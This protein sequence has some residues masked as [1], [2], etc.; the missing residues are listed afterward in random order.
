MIDVFPPPWRAYAIRPYTFSRNVLGNGNCLGLFAAMKGVCD[1]PLH[2][3]AE[4]FGEMGNGL[5]LSAVV[6]GVCDTPLHLFAKCFGK[7]EWLGLFAAMEGVCDTP[8]HIFA[9]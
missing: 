5:G 9:E 7:R 6:M 3:F 8:L 2:L 4:M 1:T